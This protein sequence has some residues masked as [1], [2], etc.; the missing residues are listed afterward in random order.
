MAHGEGLR[1]SNKPLDVDYQAVPSCFEGFEIPSNE[2]PPETWCM[3]NLSFRF[4]LRCMD[5]NINFRMVQEGY[6]NDDEKDFVMEC[7]DL[8]YIDPETTDD[9]QVNPLSTL[10]DYAAR[11][12]SHSVPALGEV[13]LLT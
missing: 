13:S 9:T 10:L 12:L 11:K 5:Q 8:C 7:L 3:L 4:F 1:R 2:P 6:M